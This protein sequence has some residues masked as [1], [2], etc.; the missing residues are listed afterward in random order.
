MTKF[1]SAA[2]PA[3]LIP[4]LNADNNLVRVAADIFKEDL[5][6][7]VLVIDAC[8]RD[9]TYKSLKVLSAQ[10]PNIS[11][12]RLKNSLG[13]GEA[14]SFGFQT[15]IKRGYDPIITMD[16]NL[17]HKAQY[18]KDFLLASQEYDL[19]IGSR[20]VD[21]VR[22]EGWK[23]R[24][25]LFSKL[26][27][28][29]VS[30]VMVKPVWDFT[31]G[32]R[33]YRR[34]FLK[35]IDLSNLHSINYIV[36]IELLYLAFHNL[37]RV[38]EIPFIYRGRGKG[39]RESK[40]DQHPKWKTLHFVLKYRAPLPEIFRH[41][42]FLKKDYKRF[43]AEYD[44]LI[45]PPK[46]K[47]NGKFQVKDGYS[48]SISVLAYNEEKI[49]GRCLDGL[50][51]QKLT[52]STIDEIIVVSSG[53]TDSTDK[54]VKEYEKKDNRI[55]L[56]TQPDRLG[57]ASAINEFLK[58]AKGEIAVLESADTV[59]RTNTLEELI[60]PFAKAEVGMTGARPMPI[61]PDKSFA[62]FCVHK[63]WQLHHHVALDSPKCGE[64]VA[65][66]N[67]IPKIPMY[68]AVD[69]AAIEGILCREGFQLAYAENAVVQNKGP[70]T[71]KDFISQ[72]RRIASG[73]LH[74]K[75][76]MGHEVATDN[77]KKVFYYVLKCQRWSVKEI[78]FMMALIMIEGYS[79]FMGKVDYYL[80]DKNPFIWD[81]AAS[82]KRMA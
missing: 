31:S 14:L 59:T 77:P 33:C 4:V 68:T 69:E 49:I 66:R 82:T 6:I 74:L 27:N 23:F 51:A 50:L 55:K 13:F 30:Y 24:R 5:D 9:D 70:E 28:M 58:I 40:I 42:T 65:F 11:I 56:I 75:A 16:G 38:K 32:Y 53:S 35:S 19:V 7:D 34:D 20:Y 44:E 15:A 2:K 81:I 62:D 17:S 73:H 78:M 41:L 67:I 57:K 80:K 22:V 25:L 54:I 37:F 3:V 43:V 12:I 29:F 64:I 10:Y 18:L 52:T 21:G 1:N 47:N 48:V 76:A 46:L 79:R 45:N 63:L 36:Q 8:L 61:N 71:I 72:R 39:R 60:K 26:A